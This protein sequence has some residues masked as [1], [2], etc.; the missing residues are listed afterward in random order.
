MKLLLV[1]QYFKSYSDI[2]SGNL[3]TTFAIPMYK[4]VFSTQCTQ[5]STLYV[6]L[7][8]G[9]IRTEEEEQKLCAER[10][11]KQ[12]LRHYTSRREPFLPSS[13]HAAL[14]CTASQHTRLTVT[15]GQKVDEKTGA[16]YISLH[17][18][19]DGGR[20][21]CYKASVTSIFR[22][23]LRG[24][25]NPSAPTMCES[26]RSSSVKKSGS[27]DPFSLNFDFRLRRSLVRSGRSCHAFI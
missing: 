15:K 11:K 10:E 7:F 6:N 25:A 14:H 8:S 24:S 26:T 5:T 12:R 2:S 20:G 22:S 1:L 23:V 3:H 21:S 13:G 4:L 18:K 16:R 19:S 17:W 27:E 9:W